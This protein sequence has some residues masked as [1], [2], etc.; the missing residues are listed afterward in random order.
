MSTWVYFAARAQ[1]AQADTLEFA[2]RQNILWRS[3]R[4]SAGSLIA[5]VGRLRPGDT[6]LLVYRQGRPHVARVAA[7]IADV[8]NPVPGTDVIERVKPPHA[9]S[10]V[11]AGYQPVDASGAVEVLHLEDVTEVELVLRGTYGGSG[12][13]HQLA[14][15]D[16]GVAAALPGSHAETEPE[17]RL[18]PADM[19]LSVVPDQAPA[20]LAAFG[21]ATVP[22]DDGPEVAAIPRPDEALRPLFDAYV[23]V[24][25]S[26]RR[27]PVRGSDS[28]WVAWGSW[29]GG[30]LSE[31]HANKE[32]RTAAIQL[33]R[34]ELLGARFAGLRVRL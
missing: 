1:A 34:D 31:D 12:T 18:A 11:D 20:P 13:I 23:M 33:L 4:N 32:T 8:A 10:L 16:A 21:P 17:E 9:E 5:N 24:D 27:A 30:G 26:S 22:A 2:T 14:P 19:A 3:A 29:E 6:I 15:E 25:W 28:I 7:K